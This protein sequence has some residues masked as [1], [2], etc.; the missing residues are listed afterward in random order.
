[1]FISGRLF[2]IVAAMN[3]IHVLS[4]ALQYI[5]CRSTE[6]PL[7]VIEKNA[8]TTSMYIQHIF[9]HG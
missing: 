7:H 6:K 9:S 8:I 4:L 1:M 3:I 2:Y 5:P